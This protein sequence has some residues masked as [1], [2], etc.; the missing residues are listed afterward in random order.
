VT[1]GVKIEAKQRPRTFVRGLRVLAS[2]GVEH[3]ARSQGWASVD[4]IEGTGCCTRERR[5]RLTLGFAGTLP[6]HHHHRRTGTR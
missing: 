5:L 2:D 3:L 6:K 4:V 1:D